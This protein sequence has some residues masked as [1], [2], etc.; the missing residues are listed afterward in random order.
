[1]ETMPLHC[2]YPFTEVRWPTVTSPEETVQDVS[3][4]VDR[5]RIIQPSKRDMLWFVEVSDNVLAYV[6]QEGRVVAQFVFASLVR[7]WDVSMVGKGTVIVT[8][9]Y[10]HVHV[11]SPSMVHVSA[12]YKKKSLVKQG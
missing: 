6:N 11:V 5:T 7:N 8:T 3:F 4:Y 1:M 12:L 2:H 9:A 10:G